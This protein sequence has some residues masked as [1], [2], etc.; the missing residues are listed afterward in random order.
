MCLESNAE[1]INLVGF[2]FSKI[3]ETR[4]STSLV[5]SLE[6]QE[7]DHANIAIIMCP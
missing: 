6:G 3:S 4:V 5:S 1:L 2:F 7:G